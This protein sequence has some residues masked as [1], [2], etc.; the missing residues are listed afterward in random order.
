MFDCGRNDGDK[1][2]L[3]H[4]PLHRAAHQITCGTGVQ[5]GRLG[6]IQTQPGG[7]FAQTQG[8]QQFGFVAVGGICQLDGA[9]QGRLKTVVQLVVTVIKEVVGFAACIR[10]GDFGQTAVDNA[11]TDADL[12]QDKTGLDGFDIRFKLFRL[13]DNIFIRHKNVFKFNGKRA[14]AFQAAEFR[15]RNQ[16]HAF[17]AAAGDEHHIFFAQLRR[18]RPNMVVAQIRYPRQDAVDAVTALDTLR[19]QLMF[20]DSGQMFDRI[21]HSRSRQH[22]SVQ[23]VGQITAFHFRVRRLVQIPGAGGLTPGGE[24]SGAACFADLA[25]YFDLHGQTKRAASLFHT[26]CGGKTAYPAQFAQKGFGIKPL[27]VD[28]FHQGFQLGLHQFGNV[29][30]KGFAGHN[31]LQIV[32]VGRSSA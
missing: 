32:K 12:Q 1:H 24:R 17:A 14:R 9:R 21:R 25:Q 20:L 5:C 26:A 15:A 8:F 7:S 30:Q 11:G 31:I 6:G 28:V 10:S 23:H 18:I 27:A 3:P 2:G 29:F 4:P 13:R 19:L 22:A 16:R